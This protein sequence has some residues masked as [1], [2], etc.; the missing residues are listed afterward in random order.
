MNT[1]DNVEHETLGDVIA[2]AMNSQAAAPEVE[3]VELAEDETGDDLTDPDTDTEES[4]GA[5]DGEQDEGAEDQTADEGEDAGEGSEEAKGETAGQPE[6]EKRDGYVKY[7]RFKKFHH[8]AKELETELTQAQQKLQQYESGH[9][10]AETISTFLKTNE[11]QP[12]DAMQALQIAAAIKNDPAKALEMLR[13][14]VESVGYATGTFLPPEERRRVETGEISEQD[15]RELVRAKAEAMR[16][17][18]VAQRHQT[19]QQEQMV[20]QAR[21]KMA[22]A[23]TAVEHQ[24]AAKDPEYKHKLVPLQREVQLLIQQRQPQTPEQARQL[25][26]DAY[27]NVN[28]QFRAVVRKPEIKPG[29]RSAP[30]GTTVTKNK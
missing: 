9:K 25:V 14:I 4:Q 29:P 27:D 11:L 3:E 24:L 6:G 18:Q 10:Y 5:D 23:V 1:K 8:R 21:A 19:Q 22:E 17:N 13:P 2:S 26:I 28:K 16:A 12:D 30:S 7:S 15:A 20:M